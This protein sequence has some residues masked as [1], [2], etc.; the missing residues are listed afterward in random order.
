M[1]SQLRFGEFLIKIFTK[2]VNSNYKFLFVLSSAIFSFVQL[3]FS[4]LSWVFNV[5][6]SAQK[7]LK[8]KL[9][10]RESQLDER[11]ALRKISSVLNLMSAKLISNV[12]QLKKKLKLAQ[13]S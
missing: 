13:L 4:E 9:S 1:E 2:K 10:K 6:I 5:V 8:L 3:F 7:Q 11:S 12:A